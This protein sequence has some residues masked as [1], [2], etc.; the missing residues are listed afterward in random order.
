MLS[1]GVHL[2]HVQPASILKN[3]V[4]F[5][6]SRK[7]H[8]GNQV[9]LFRRTKLSDYIVIQWHGRSRYSVCRT[10]DIY[11]RDSRYVGDHVTRQQVKSYDACLASGNVN[12]KLIYSDWMFEC[13]NTLL[14]SA[15]PAL[16]RTERANAP[17]N[18]AVLFL[19]KS[20]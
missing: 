13:Y 17:K 18:K 6:P 3:S 20:F 4:C 15:T 5:K 8:L 14:L 19:R 11:D 7:D 10:T 9:N 16:L 2:N 12:V 1:S